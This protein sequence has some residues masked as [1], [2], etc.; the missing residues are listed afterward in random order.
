MAEPRK[1]EKAPEKSSPSA[2][3]RLIRI[4]APAVFLNI[5]SGAMLYTARTAHCSSLP[6]FKNGGPQKLATFLTRLGSLSAFVEFIVNPIFGKLSDSY[7]R[8]AIAPVGNLSTI[9]FRLLMFLNPKT[10]W[11]IVLEQTIT[12]PLIT[13]FFT[14]WR[15]SAS[16]ILEGTE[17]ATFNAK[18][19]ISAG[20]A[21][22]A[23]PLKD[24]KWSWNAINNFVG[25]LG[26]GLVVSGVGAKTMMK[27]FGPKLFTSV[28]NICNAVSLFCYSQ[29]FPLNLFLGSTAGM[30]LGLLFSLPG[31]RKRDAIE[32]L[33][34][35]HGSDAGFGKGFI[36][37]A[38]MNWRGPLVFGSLYTYGSKKGFSGLAFLAAAMTCL[39]AEVLTKSIS[40]EDF[41]P[42]SKLEF[43]KP[44]TK[45]QTDSALPEPNHSAYVTEKIESHKK[46]HAEA[47]RAAE[48][49]HFSASNLNLE[50]KIPTPSLLDSIDVRKRIED[51]HRIHELAVS[52]AEK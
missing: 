44:E 23:G 43:S 36:S 46:I 22:V 45:Q 38:L 34:M 13:S 20:S 12:I 42:K 3:S 8:R 2:E 5:L 27:A 41:N 24:L 52:L 21:I 50:N 28:S 10:V 7:G 35:K 16:D 39:G 6:S 48:E 51:H 19:G 37:G 49:R 47:V 1:E 9:F 29:V 31:A 40:N 17:Y 15:A 25:T 32:A 33:V 4:I 26:I 14:T 18:I 11:P 30:V